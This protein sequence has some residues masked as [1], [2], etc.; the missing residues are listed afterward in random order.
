MYSLYSW[1]S[2][3]ASEG[4]YSFDPSCL[5]AQAYLQLC[6]A[7]WQLHQVNS[8]NVSPSGCLPALS[9]EGSVVESGFWRTV[10]F[11]KNQ[12]FNLDE[13]LDEEQLAQATAYMSVIQDGLGDAILFSWYLVSENFADAIRPRLARLFGF[14][15]SLAIPTQLQ[16]YARRRLKAG[17]I[18]VEQETDE[19]EATAAAD[20]IQS[21]SLRSR[22]PRIYLLAKEGFRRH[23]DK[24]THSIYNQ[25]EKYLELLSKKLDKKQY[26]FGK[27]PTTL[28]TAAYGYLSM[29]LY[30]DLPQ[31]TLKTA[32]IE[33]Y[34]NLAALCDRIHAQLAM[35]TTVSDQSLLAGIGSVV[36]HTISRYATIPALPLEK[37]END[38][39]RAG[40]VRSTFGALI[41]FFGYI[42][43]NGILSAP[44]SQESQVV[45]DL[46]QLPALDVRS[47]VSAI[48][49]L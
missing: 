36:K 19:S 11:M 25:T 8:T 39:D 48:K 46:A 16:D 4:L 10:Q 15:L 35:P 3:F 9:Y 17:G 22:L 13:S 23:A 7:E 1:G 34:A 38:P 33:K 47:M 40:K 41:V 26:F 32:I 31:N 28:D 43:Y 21:N 5:S 49:D 29:I 2:P 37:P 42:I 18:K 20:G 14:P 24:S 6:K 45:A 30:V 12:G 27:Q 44:A